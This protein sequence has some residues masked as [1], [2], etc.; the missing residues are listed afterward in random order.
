MRRKKSR[1]LGAA[2]AV[3]ALIGAGCGESGD[4]RAEPAQQNVPE[5]AAKPAKAEKDVPKALAENRAQAN[6]ILPDGQ[7]DP[8]LEELRGHP[9]VV[10]QWASWCEPCR[11]EF[12]YFQDAAEKH[13]ADVAF[14]GVD[15]QDDRAAAEAFLDELPVP[16]PSIDDP[17]AE[18]I[19]SLGGGVVS[20][21]TVFIDRKGEIQ[22]VFQGV[23][24]SPAQLEADIERY[25]LS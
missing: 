3:A 17:G 19:A 24:T 25:L 9:V 5:Q 23:Y 14:L 21:T 11:A 4:E 7:L 12:P 8:K 18:Q 10:N 13:A 22:F 2:F 20:P 15:M 6:E 16:Y 1:V